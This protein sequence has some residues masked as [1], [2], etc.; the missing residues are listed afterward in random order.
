MA[1]KSAR[2]KSNHEAIDLTGEDD[3]TMPSQSPQSPP[4]NQ[5]ERD[6]WLQPL[7]DDE[8]EADDV[9]VASTQ[10]ANSDDVAATYQL[11]GTVNTKIVGVQ[12]Y[13]G[14]ASFG[15]HVPLRR[16]PR[17]Q[18]GGKLS[19]SLVRVMLISLSMIAMLSELR[20]FSVIRL[21]ISQGRWLLNWLPSWI[22][23]LYLLKA[24]FLVM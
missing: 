13:H 1:P 7:Q 24:R 6:S 12:Y 2:R 5:L 3:A 17:N 9:V 22:V 11:Y 4:P 15:E 14:L 16:E 19:G 23:E 10:D 18:V 21:G 20:M 8:H